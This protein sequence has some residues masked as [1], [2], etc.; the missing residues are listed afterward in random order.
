ML[1][2]EQCSLEDFFNNKLKKR[3]EI[4]NSFLGDI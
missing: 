2:H 1:D 3:L 4:P